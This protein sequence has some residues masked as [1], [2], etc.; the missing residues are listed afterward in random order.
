MG[1]ANVS[2]L[3]SEGSEV[4]D[5]IRWTEA[6]WLVLVANAL[7]LIASGMPRVAAV[8]KAQK[9][10]L[11]K[12]RHRAPKPIGQAF[13]PSNGSWDRA[14]TAFRKLDV[15]ERGALL[16]KDAQQ[17]VPAP[18]P[19]PKAQDFMPA[20][21][22][23]LVRWTARERAHMA[24]AVNLLRKEPEHAGLSLAELYI[25]AQRMT[26]PADRQRSEAGIKQA[27]YAKGSILRRQHDEGVQ[28]GWQWPETKD[29]F[30]S[31][32]AAPTAA[33]ASTEAPAAPAPAA[34]APAALQDP[35]IASA[36]SAFGTTMMQA[37]ETLLA[38][39]D[40][41]VMLQLTD[42]LA[43][44]TSTLQ[45]RTGLMVQELLQVQ[46]GH[47]ATEVGK[48]LRDVL[49]AELGQGP[50]PAPAPASAAPAPSSP[51]NGTHAP[52]PAAPGLRIDIIGTMDP[53]WVQ[54]IR[55]A[56]PGDEVRIFDF[57]AGRDYAPHRG[58][59]LIVMQQGKLPRSLQAKLT[60]SGAKPVFVRDAAGHV[61]R[62]VQD[63]KGSAAGAT[64]Q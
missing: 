61:L 11:D 49:L 21:D 51:A 38:A 39:R 28:A 1:T 45:E 58:R 62:A 40:Q 63:I 17:R 54:R 19:K 44:A 25:K 41:Q 64:L 31:G 5:K 22:A 47:I 50:A 14:V 3:R 27:M 56:A 24:A 16:G 26:L 60:T 15:A 4:M 55:D 30:R 32:A 35:G 57:A 52:P 59:H 53:E 23:G 8:Q 6:E 7:P 34:S 29:P 48:S 9:T 43:A 10:M 42:R 20:S 33:P 36:A 37:L 18:P 46:I 2:R 13:A 12:S